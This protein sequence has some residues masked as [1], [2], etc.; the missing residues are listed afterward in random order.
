MSDIIP[1]VVVSMPSQLFTLARKFQ[2]ASNGKIFIGKIDTDPTL[3]ENQI[4]VY[5]E[6]EDGSYIPVSQP[7]VINQAGLPVYNGQ[8]AK[9]VTV[10]GHSMAVYDS[11]GAQQFYYPNVLKYDPDMLRSELLTNHGASLIAHKKPYE[12]S[13]LRTAADYF[14][15]EINIDD[16]GAKGDALLINGD[17]NPNRTDDSAAIQK[18]LVAAYR[19]GGVK[20]TATPWKSYYV[21]NRVFTLATGHTPGT[22]EQNLFPTRRIQVIDFQ[23]ARFIG[24]DDISDDSNVFIESGYIDTNG[25]IKTVFGQPVESQLTYGTKIGNLEI[26]NFNRGFRLRNHVYGC[27]LHDVMGVNTQQIAYTERCFV[28]NWNRINATGSYTDGLPRF[29]FRDNTNIMPL[30][31]VNTGDHDVGMLFESATESVKLINCGIENYKTWGIKLSGATYSLELDSCYIESH[32]GVAITGNQIKHLTIN[33]C[34]FFGGMT[35]FGDMGESTNIR[36][37]PNNIVHPNTKMWDLS[38]VSEYNLSDISLENTLHDATKNKPIYDAKLAMNIN[39]T[40]TS[41]NPSV[42]VSNSGVVGKIKQCSGLHEIMVNGRTSKGTSSR[43]TVGSVVLTEKITENSYQAIYKTGISY[44]DTQLVYVNVTINHLY[45]VWKWAGLIVGESVFKFSA[46][47]SEN[48]SIEN[49]NGFLVVRSRT[50][51]G[52]T[53]TPMGGEIRLI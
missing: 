51:S 27:E 4:Q 11:Y 19:A 5:L 3:P 7:L 30:Y 36:W 35:I 28:T 10:E 6:N 16:F 50:L 8:I 44:S 52:S 23:G 24:K 46:S 37:M 48:I 42:G 39:Q 25:D 18:A 38:K 40:L 31:S 32:T 1:N 15:Q 34:W 12:G 33:N 22:A 29:H 49:S 9:F 53:I 45:G 17:K 21:A 47:D 13:V 2:A 41:Y 43:F 26:I 14:N 20:V